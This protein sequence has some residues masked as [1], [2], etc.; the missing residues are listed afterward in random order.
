MGR[1]GDTISKYTTLS[2]SVAEQA[3]PGCAKSG[4]LT[5]DNRLAY[6]TRSC[7]ERHAE[8]PAGDQDVHNRQSLDATWDNLM[9]LHYQAA[10]PNMSAQ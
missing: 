1:Q 2:I 8:A 9:H 3:N 4:R 6:C 10:V 5:A 7:S